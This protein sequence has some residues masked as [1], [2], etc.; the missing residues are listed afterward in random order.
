MYYVLSIGLSFKRNV[1]HCP[2][3]H[4]A[5]HIPDNVITFS[6]FIWCFPNQQPIIYRLGGSQIARPKGVV[7]RKDPKKL[8]YFHIKSTNL[9]RS[10]A[11]F[12]P[13][14]HFPLI[15]KRNPLSA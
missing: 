13:P 10:I 3:L 14:T 15:P 1:S 6:S 4:E 11:G 7:L 12:S 8:S 9:F 5:F 2:C